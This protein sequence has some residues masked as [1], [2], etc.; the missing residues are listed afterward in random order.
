MP[1]LFWMPMIMMRGLWQAAEADAQ[2]L[3]NPCA[4]KDKNPG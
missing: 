2:A 3:F 4:P 1:F